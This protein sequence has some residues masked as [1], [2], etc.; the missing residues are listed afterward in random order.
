MSAKRDDLRL[1]EPPR[2]LH[3][4]E[5]ALIEQ[6]LRP[7]FAGRD[8]IRYQLATARVRAEDSGDTRT[9]RFKLA[10]EDVRRACVSVRVPVEAEA[11]DEDGTPIAVLLHVVDGLLDELEIYR[12]DGQPIQRDDLGALDSVVVNTGE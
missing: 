9:I 3:A 5:R 12:V 10:L 1:L 8:E 7:P 2:D 11:S 6:L 4:H